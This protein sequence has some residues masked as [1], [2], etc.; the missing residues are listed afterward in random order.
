MYVLDTNVIS[1]LCRGKPNQSAE[2]RAWAACVPVSQ[3][4]LTAI[5]VLELERG[6][7]TL[8]RRTPP[9]GSVLHTLPASRCA[10]KFRRPR[11][12]IHRQHRNVVRDYART[13]SALGA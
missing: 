7:L 1:E 3:L 5:N 2:I 13:Q 11:P 12:A 4:F 9:Q 10:G 8:E 6:V